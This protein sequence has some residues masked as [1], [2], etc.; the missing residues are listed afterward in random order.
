M[1]D[2]KL[3]GSKQRPW[4][5]RFPG[6]VTLV[7]RWIF[8]VVVPAWLVILAVYH[9]VALGPEA[10]R[11]VS[12]EI[13]WFEFVHALIIGYLPASIAYSLRGARR[14]LHALRPAL[15]LSDKQFRDQLLALGSFNGAH[16]LLLVGLFVA[17]LQAS[18]LIGPSPS[19]TWP[20]GRP[21][22][23]DPR[24]SWIMLRSGIIAALGAQLGYVD[25]TV[26]RRFSKIGETWA[27]IDLLDLSPVAP[28]ARRGLRSVVIWIGLT[29]LT[30]LLFLVSW[31]QPTARV[32]LLLILGVAA[33]VLLLPVLGVH[34][35]AREAK[36]AELERVREALRSEREA[37]LA[38][39][40]PGA[41]ADPRL[42]NLI[43][44]ERRIESA[45]T[46]PFD[47]GTLV[48]FGFYVALGV[49]SW[50]GGAIV[51]RLLGR[52]LE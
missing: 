6:S 38:A 19:P 18:L 2:T 44:Y 46:W 17:L 48:R 9:Y 21:P 14:D 26:A 41:L 25:V 52:V 32:V 39:R 20:D 47:P 49:G 45:R 28:F 10:F 27:V 23:G 11:A 3:R 51:E 1:R 13:A 4:A 12:P 36:S 5:I 16:L 31:A 34:R 35:R 43:A 50:L 15:R 24:M 37:Q 22:L 30:S 29:I 40:E 8:A 42:S 33:T 7:P